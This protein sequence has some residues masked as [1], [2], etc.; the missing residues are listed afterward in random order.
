LGAET[1]GS[2]VQPASRAGLY[3]L[4]PT[5]GTVSVTNVLGGT[6]FDSIGP[7]ART[8]KDVADMVGLL[9]GEDFTGALKG[10]WQ[11]VRV[12]MVQYDAWAPVPFVVEPVEE[13]TTQTVCLPAWMAKSSRLISVQK[14]EMRK[15]AEK[16]RKLGGKVVED[17]P[18]SPF[19]EYSNFMSSRG[20]D[21]DSFGS[22]Y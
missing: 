7:I 14:A 1:D 9:M 3:A 18:L 10:S 20:I 6:T 5:P 4:K 2:I 12:G 13:F 19:W 16:I 21:V 17:V 22:Q 8:A 15:A 11:G